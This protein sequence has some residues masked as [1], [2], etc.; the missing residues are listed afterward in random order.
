[1]GYRCPLFLFIAALLALPA[2]GAVSAADAEVT[3][4]RVGLHGLSTRIVIDLDRPVEAKVFTLAGPARL[5]ID[6]PEVGWRLPQKPLPENTGVLARLRYGLFQP[7]NSRI[8][9][10]L[11]QPSRVHDAIALPGDGGQ[12]DRLVIDMA[13]A[14]GTAFLQSVAAPPMLIRGSETQIVSARPVT[15][16]TQPQSPEVGPKPEIVAQVPVK[17]APPMVQTPKP[18]AAAVPVPAGQSETRLSSLRIPRK[19]EVPGQA[20]K[21]IIVIDPGHG[22]VDPGAIGVSGIYEKH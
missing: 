8:V 14:T 12:A 19:P 3:D 1:M 5:V 7:G 10:D 13:R 11:S 6:L 9:I 20:K 16:T 18:V 2:S 15:A 17:P 22:G 21:R 4:I